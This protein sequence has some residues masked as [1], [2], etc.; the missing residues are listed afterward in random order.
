MSS[1]LSNKEISKVGHEMTKT[2]ELAESYFNKVTIPIVF[3]DL[4][5]NDNSH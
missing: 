4:K 1:L 5:E 2:K 3:K